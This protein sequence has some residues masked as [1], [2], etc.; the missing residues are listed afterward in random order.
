ME[1]FSLWLGTPTTLLDVCV[2]SW[3]RFHKV[4]LYVDESF[5][6][7]F[8]QDLIDKGQLELR[9]YDDITIPDGIDPTRHSVQ[10]FADIWRYT[11]LYQRGGTWLDCDL[12]LLRPVPLHREYIIASELTNQSGFYKSNRSF[13]P[14]IS[15]LKFPKGC[16]L[17]SDVLEQCI[18]DA[19]KKSNSNNNKFQK[20]FQKKLMSHHYEYLLTAIMPPHFFCPIFW[21][22][23][24]DIFTYP[25][26]QWVNRGQKYAV[27]LPDYNEM[28]EDSIGIHLWNNLASKKGINYDI[29]KLGTL[30]YN[31]VEM[32]KK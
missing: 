2:R 28:M 13:I 1:V 3:C 21:G 26:S 25:V 8:F 29:P 6:R 14:Q 30:Y 22:F 27:E 5:I 12:F 32:V 11:Y 15:C 18:F 24:V 17:L 7:G 4:A 16:P 10:E 31:L 23:A 9:D 19:K 20:V